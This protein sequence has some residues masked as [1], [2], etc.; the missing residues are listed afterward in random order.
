MIPG[1]DLVPTDPELI[2]NRSMHGE[3]ALGVSHRLESF[4]LP[5]LL[6]SVLV[7]DF[8]A[9]VLVLTGPVLD[10]RKH[11]AMSGRIGPELVGYEPHGRSSFMLQSSTKE[12]L[13]RSTIAPLGNQNIDHISILVDSAPQ[14]E[15]LSA[16]LDEEFVDMPDVTES[17]LFSSKTSSVLGTELQTPVADRLVRNLD[18]SLGEQVLNLAEAESEPMV[19]G[20]GTTSRSSPPLRTV[21]ESF[22]SHRSSLSRASDPTRFPGSWVSL[23]TK[24]R[25]YDRAVPGRCIDPLHTLAAHKVVIKGGV[26]GAAARILMCRTMAT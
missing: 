5:F 14:V 15:T 4:H 21:R 18:S 13:G 11:F 10:E 12:A 6:A 20:K 9:V 19:P 24:S 1:S 8:S 22:P 7:R 2:L 25:V 3:E 16:D 17:T 23:P 26:V